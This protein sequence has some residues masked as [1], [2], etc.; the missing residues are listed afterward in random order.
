MTAT[1]APGVKPS[2]IMIVPNGAISYDDAVV[3]SLVFDAVI[4]ELDSSAIRPVLDAYGNR[5]PF[6]GASR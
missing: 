6:P 4:V 2:I 3:L 1:Q 5:L